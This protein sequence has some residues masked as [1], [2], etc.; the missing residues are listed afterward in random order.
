M[1]VFNTSFMLVAA[2]LL[3]SATSCKK[4]KYPELGD[5]LYAE[6]ITSKGTMVAK[7]T[8]QKTPVTVANFVAL[9]EGNH[10][11]V[12]DQ[13]KGKPFYNGLIF[14]R[15]MNDFM[16]QGG[17]PNAT[18]SGSPGYK[19]G[20]EFDETLKHDK[21]GILS[22]ANPGPNSNGSQFFITEKPTPWLD[23]KHSV[24]GELVLGLEI[25][26]SISNVKTAARDKP[27][28][29]VVIEQINIIRQGF[30]ARKF[31]AVKVWETELP[32]LEEKAKKK[33]EEA[34]K[35]AEEEQRV[36]KEK[37]EKAAKEIVD[38]LNGYKEKAVTKN[39][40]L[41]TYTI[42]K[43]T[44]PKPK[45]GQK[46]KVN[47]EGYFP[48]GQLFGSNNKN[49]EQTFGIYSQGKENQGWYGEMS[50][51]ISP[52]VQMIAGFKEGVAD[53]RVGDKTYMYLPAHLAWGERGA[54]PS[55]PPNA[56]VVYI[57]EMLRIE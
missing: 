33:A 19:F 25:Q 9:A 42:T 35:K 32:L 46:V 11:M 44:G 28:E 48:D 47:Y 57:V 45:Q 14:H 43:G 34:R 21:P 17:D 18:G 52:D 4:D 3:M 8:P 1:K 27:V 24:F 10:P 15:V 29:D 16:I 23:N 31:D 7:L 38:V 54:P 5:G 50:M 39:S 6:F 53:M 26:D 22:M 2:V 51:V 20:D 36:A 41:M 55:I 13:Y 30:D 49:L 12:S 37:A 56:D 40:G